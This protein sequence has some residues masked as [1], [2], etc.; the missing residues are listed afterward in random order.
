[1]SINNLKLNG[2][3]KVRIKYFQKRKKEMMAS[4]EETEK[5]WRQAD[6][7]IELKPLGGDFSKNY[8]NNRIKLGV[9][10]WQS[11]NSSALAFQKVQVALNVLIESNPTLINLRPKKKVY[12]KSSPLMKALYDHS[13]SVEDLKLKLKRVV[14]NQAK[15]GVAFGQTYSRFDTHPAKDLIGLDPTTRKPEYKDVLVEDYKGPWMEP[16]NNYDVWWDDQ[17]KPFD[18]LSMDDWMRAVSFT[19]D[20]AESIFGRS[21]HWSMVEKMGKTSPNKRG[22]KEQKDFRDDLLHG[23][24]YESV[25]KDRMIVEL[26]NVPVLDVPLPVS[27]RLSLGYAMWNLRNSDTIDGIGVPEIMRQN[28]NLYNKINNMS[29]DQL[30]L[31]IY[32]MFFY[33]GTL[34]TDDTEIRIRPGAGQRVLDPTKVTWMNIPGPGSEVGEKKAE[35]KKEMDDDTGITPTLAG[36]ALTNKTAFEVEQVLRSSMRRL[37]T[38]L[39][40]LKYFLKLDALNRLD[41]LKLE[42]S[43]DDVEE[44][45]DQE[46]IDSYKEA[47]EEEP[48]MF[49]WDEE[50]GILYK[51]NTPELLLYL[52]EKD[53]QFVPSNEARFFKTTPAGMRWEGDMDIDIE[54][55]LQKLPELER[56]QTLE[57]ANMVIPLLAGDPMQNLKPIKQLS[58]VF[59]LDW[60][61]WVPNDWL[62][63]EPQPAIDRVKIAEQAAGQKGAPTTS[64]GAP[65]SMSKEIKPGGIRNVVN[66]V[67]RLFSKVNP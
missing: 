23:F 2:A 43:T 20:R 67:G 1:M 28:L 31:M 44:I 56:T 59:D 53:G 30:V 60:K 13:V 4:R 17:A 29:V 14:L 62:L 55:M 24:L 38:P 18:M 65:V 10:D 36:E 3:E 35:L 54:P 63:I 37:A 33:D 50:H 41:I 46:D 39:D 32:K 48:D 25:S 49:R 34:D 22:D 26:N 8:R 61:E 5:R 47:M 11:D 19:K 51:Y 42:Y 16:L 7:E 66:K 52:E 6:R 15:Y 12:E 40:G 27:K 58:E 21:K 57:F 9:S 64:Q 45:V